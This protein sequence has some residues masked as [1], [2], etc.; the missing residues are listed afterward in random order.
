M[1]LIK[2]PECGK[3]ISDQ[4]E[5]CIHCGYPIKKNQEEPGRIVQ[6]DEADIDRE[7][8]LDS[9]GTTGKTST[10]NAEEKKKRRRN[11]VIAIVVVVGII[12]IFV[13]VVE[14]TNHAYTRAQ[15]KA[16]QS[17]SSYQ[18]EKSRL[19]T[20]EREKATLDATID[21]LESNK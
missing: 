14:Y 10:E 13:A 20:L 8:I 16:Q 15:R 3:E 5:V 17:Y 6:E 2:C 11:A 18:S 4:A 9:V 19:D 21:A 1:A 12:V 7:T